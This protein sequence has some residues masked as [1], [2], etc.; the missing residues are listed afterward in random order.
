MK[1]FAL[2]LTLSLALGFSHE[3]ESELTLK[4]V[5]QL[6]NQSTLKMLQGFLLN[7]DAMVLEG[8]KEIAEHPVPK[9]GPLRYID[10]SM[11][12]DFS[13]MM[14]AFERQV[15]GGAEEV[16]RFIKEGKRDEAF[17]TYTNMLQGCMACH[18]L[19]RDRIKGR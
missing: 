8:A 17:R 2:L 16:I 12:E 10:P 18:E 19:F 1:K 3:L 14:P 5:M 7:N 9:G 11:R 13:R 15:H 6:V 4:Q